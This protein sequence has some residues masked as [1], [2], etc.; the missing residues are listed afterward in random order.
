MS[1]V[2]H[3]FERAG[4]GKAP[5]SCVGVR[6]N[7]FEMP[8]F[9]RKPGGSCNYCGTGILNEYVIK[10]ADGGEFVVGCDCVEKTGALVSGFRE[11]RIARIRERRALKVSERQAERNARWATDHEERRA[12]KSFEWLSENEALDEKL[13]AYAGANEFIVSMAQSV[14]FWGGLT[15]GQTAAVSRV[16][17]AEERLEQQRRNSRHVGTIGKRMQAS[18]RVKFS[19]QLFPATWNRAARYITVMETETGDALVWFSSA[20]WRETEEF[21][22]IKFT[23]AE[24]DERNGVMQT[25]IKRASEVA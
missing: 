23:P 24:H 4:L 17:A 8:G 15:V 21:F 16:L 12:M 14:K 2:L 19:K 10:S 9:G 22:P 1:A 25:I 7:W 11:A 20:G 13:K 5:F 3:P 18:V 6:E